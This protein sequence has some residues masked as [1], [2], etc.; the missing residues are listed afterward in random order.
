MEGAYEATLDYV[1][2]RKAFGKPI[3]DFQNTRFKLAEIATAASR[4]AAPSS[5]AASKTCVAGKLDTATAS[6]AK[7]LGHRHAGPGDRRVPAAASAA[8]AT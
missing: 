3:A 2:E 8:T 4:S 1:R 5:T 6:M 7:L